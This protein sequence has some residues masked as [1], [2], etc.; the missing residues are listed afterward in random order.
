MGFLRRIQEDF[1]STTATSFMLGGG[2]AVNE[3]NLRLSTGWWRALRYAGALLSSATEPP[4]VSDKI[5][6]AR[7]VNTRTHEVE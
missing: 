5:I 4:W 3:D 6:D 1:I 7:F 2:G